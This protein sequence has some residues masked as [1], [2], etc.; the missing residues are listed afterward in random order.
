M[1]AKVLP[2][3]FD[4]WHIIEGVS[5]PIKDTGW[6]KEVSKN[7]YSDQK[8]SVDGTTEFLDEISSKYE[9][10]IIHR[11]ENSFW[12]GKVEMCNMPLKDLTDCILMQI[13]V[14]EIWD[15]PILDEVLDFAE[16][17]EGFDMMQFL[18][19]YYVGPDLIITSENTYG[20]KITEWVRLWKIGSKTTWKTHEPPV[21]HGCDKILNRNFTKEKGWI[22]DHYAYFTVEQLE[23]KQ[24]F[25]GYYDAVQQWNNLQ[26]NKKF[27]CKLRDFLKWLDDDAIVDVIK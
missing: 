3:V 2:F 4:E 14:D 25:Y 10:V 19:R 8:L 11:K 13:D 9:N 26:N 15:K 17:H 24:N 20:N 23:F 1:Q 21:L 12:E 16:S 7:F 22:F 18:C 5:R 27:P 6:C